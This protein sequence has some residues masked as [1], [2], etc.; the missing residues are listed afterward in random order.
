LYLRV[1]VCY[2]L[3]NPCS[4]TGGAAFT[5]S[6]QLYASFYTQAR[7]SCKYIQNAL[8]AQTAVGIVRV[9]NAYGSSRCLHRFS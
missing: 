5:D 3:W 4:V 8:S 7:V 2:I 9:N 1:F 6:Q